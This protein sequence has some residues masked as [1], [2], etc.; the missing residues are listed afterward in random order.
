[1]QIGKEGI[2]NMFMNMVLE[3]LKLKLKTFKN[4]HMQSDTFL[5]REWNNHIF[6]L[7]IIQMMASKHEVL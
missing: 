2:E 4:T 1:V 7:G 6:N 3:K 5:T